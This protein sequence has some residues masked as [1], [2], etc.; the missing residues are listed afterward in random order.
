MRILIATGIYPP[1]IGGPAQYAKHLKE[2]FEASG[3]DV[4]VKFF[5]LERMLP[6]G[7]RHLYYFFKIF[8]AVLKSEVVFALDTFSVALPAILAAEILGKK[9]IIRTGGDFLW[10]SY[11]E[12]TGDLVLLK[13]FYRTSIGKFSRKEKLIFKLTGWV[14]R[15]STAVIFSTKWQKDIFSEPYKL[16]SKKLFI[17]ENFYGP[18]EISRPFSE[19]NFIAGTRPL[20]WKN[21][22]RLSQAFNKVK[23]NDES[24]IYDNTTKPYELFMDR[25]SSAYA[26]ILV[27]L[28]D[29]SPNLILDAIRYNK[30]FIV[31]RET[32]LYDRIQ[33]CAIF[34]DPEN[35][36]DIAQKIVWLSNESN[37]KSQ[38][39][40]IREFNF[41]HPW[42]E[43]A[44]E[45]IDIC[46]KF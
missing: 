24:L 27:S 12:R 13:N 21:E 20:K 45:F 3:H 4:A 1:D 6:T 37:Y 15:N 38:E 36:D 22:A 35:V 25:L 11:V 43:I 30:P 18:K 14:L 2:E 41:T 34:V 31:T 10:E 42:S 40:K 29:V 28:G 17:V 39:S 19:K 26:V 5:R 33:S 9:F 7:L 16:D 8:P 32:G 44:K 46:Q 23:T